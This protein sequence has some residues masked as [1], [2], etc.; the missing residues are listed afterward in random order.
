MQHHEQV[1]EQI[2][3]LSRQL[4][5]VLRYGSDHGFNRLLTQ[6]LGGFFD[7]LADKF[8]RPGRAV[9]HRCAFGDNAFESM[10]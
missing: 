8:C 3:D 4:C 5:V 6:F 7:A 1:I 10:E 2:G 9:G